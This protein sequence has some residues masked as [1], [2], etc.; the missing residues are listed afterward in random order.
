MKLGGRDNHMP[1]PDCL[2]ILPIIAEL[3]LRKD[4]MS[5]ERYLKSLIAEMINMKSLTGN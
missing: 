3:K 4:R 5:P 1:L 2:P